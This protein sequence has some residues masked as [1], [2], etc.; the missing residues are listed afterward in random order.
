MSDTRWT[1]WSYG[2]VHFL[3]KSKGNGPDDFRNFAG[4]VGDNKWYGYQMCSNTP[5]WGWWNFSYLFSNL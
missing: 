5:E 3:Y 2:F 1:N 4:I